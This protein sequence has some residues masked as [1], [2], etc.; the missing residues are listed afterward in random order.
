MKT[1]LT[2]VLTLVVAA[3]GGKIA[4]DDDAGL[5]GT[6][7]A[8]QSQPG[9]AGPSCHSLD[10]VVCT[11]GVYVVSC[12]CA[13]GACTCAKDGALVKSVPFAQCACTPSRTQLLSVYA[14]CGFP[15]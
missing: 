7:G 2:L 9:T 1:A 5:A 15:Y 6:C 11:T 13:A 12:D 10:S 14:S 4:P 8:H 3:C